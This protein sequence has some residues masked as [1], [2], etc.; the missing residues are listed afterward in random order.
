MP[1]SKPSQLTLQRRATPQSSAG[2]RHHIP[3]RWTEWLCA[4]PL[5]IDSLQ[6]LLGTP[7]GT[8][9]RSGY[10]A[11]LARSSFH[12]ARPQPPTRHI[13]NLASRK[14][15]GRSS[16]CLAKQSRPV[17]LSL[18]AFKPLSTSLVRRE[19]PYDKIDK[20]HEEQIQISLMLELG[21][22]ASSNQ[23]ASCA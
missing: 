10:A 8:M 14:S 17:T 23:I 16:L 15:L 3:S 1:I 22:R 13:T 2:E 21:R 6:R 5:A 9:F 18:A 4:E 7:I 12:A 19:G 11:S 20:K